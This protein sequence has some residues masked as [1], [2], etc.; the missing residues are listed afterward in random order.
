M[1]KMMTLKE[2]LF[3]AARANDV[4]TVKRLIEEGADVNTRNER[5]ESLLH[6]ACIHNHVKLAQTLITMRADIEACNNYSSTPLHFVYT[7]RER[8]AMAKLLLRLKANPNAQNNSK[9]T[10]FH[11][12]CSSSNHSQAT[13]DTAMLFLKHG[14]DPEITDLGNSTALHMAC[15]NGFIDMVRLL[16][17][18]GVDVNARA[19]F[20]NTPL[21]LA[22]SWGD[23]DITRLLLEAGADVYATD[24]NGLTPLDHTLRLDPSHYPKKQELIDLFRD[25]APGEYFRAFCEHEGG[26][27]P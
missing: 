2:K 1:I 12:V 15:V 25:H 13:I 9:R 3:Y 6:I 23:P 5:G 22:C 26:M 7:D 24:E 17:D 16:I 19:Y 8:P 18:H 11:C 10:P 4:K 27:A 21:H 14:A 20:D